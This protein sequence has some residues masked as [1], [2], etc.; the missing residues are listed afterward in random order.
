MLNNTSIFTG[1]LLISIALSLFFFKLRSIRLR[2]YIL[3]TRMVTLE[4]GSTYAYGYKHSFLNQK[5]F[6]LT[7]PEDSENIYVM[8][9]T[10][11]YNYKKDVEVSIFRGVLVI[12][13]IHLRNIFYEEKLNLDEVE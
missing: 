5:H 9:E 13:T 3:T 12:Y 6:Q 10:T 1:G 7:I 4:N 2:K 8:K 11:Y